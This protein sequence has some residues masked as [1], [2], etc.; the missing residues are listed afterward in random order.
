MVWLKP[1]YIY[2]LLPISMIRLESNFGQQKRNPVFG[3]GSIRDTEREPVQPK[4]PAKERAKYLCCETALVRNQSIF[5]IWKGNSAFRASC[6]CFQNQRT[7]QIVGV[8]KKI[9]KTKQNFNGH[10][11]KIYVSTWAQIFL[12]VTF[13][14]STCSR[15]RWKMFFCNFFPNPAK[16]GFTKRLSSRSLGGEARKVSAYVWGEAQDLDVNEAIQSN[17][18][19]SSRKREAPWRRGK[20]DHIQNGL[21]GRKTGKRIWKWREGVKGVSDLEFD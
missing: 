9:A 6:H 8:G 18:Q 15:G 5:L 4:L 19:R 17:S 3:L 10:D 16:I 2:S 7:S 14:S 13:Q 20:E 21:W 11:R 1:T 12:E